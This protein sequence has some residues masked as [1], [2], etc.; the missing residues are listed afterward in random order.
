VSVVVDTNVIAYYLL[1][2]EPFRKESVTFWHEA[3]DVWAPASWEIEFTN[4]V[5]LSVK[6][7][8]LDPEEALERLRLAAQLRITSVPVSEL[9][10]GSLSRAINSNHPAYDTVFVELAARLRCPL[11]TFDRRVLAKFREIAVRP[12]ALRAGRPDS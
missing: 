11:A 8:V 10:Q 4:T 1:G 9:W 12:A 7:G 6:A 5:W 3:K 2:T